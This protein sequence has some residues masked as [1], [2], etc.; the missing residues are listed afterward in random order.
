MRYPAAAL[1][2]SLLISVIGC[3]QDAEVP[4][5]P[6]PT[7]P[8]LAAAS[9]LAFR[10]VSAGGWHTCALTTT[11]LAYCW[12]VREHRTPAPVSGGLKFLMLSAGGSYIGDLNGQGPVS[13]GVTTALRLY[14]W[15]D[16]LVPHEVPGGRRFRAVSVGY[17]HTCAVNPYDVAFCWGSDQ[18]GQ[19]GTGPGDGSTNTPTRV[20]GGHKWRLVFAGASHTC[21]ATQDNKGYCWG[22]NNFNQ[23]GIGVPGGRHPEPTPIAG[24][25]NWRQ[26]RAGSGVNTGLNSVEIDEAV[27]CGVT[28]SDQAYCWGAG[29]TGSAPGA[30]STPKLVAGGR[31]YSTVQPG[32]WHSCGLTLAGAVFCWGQNDFGMLGRTGGSSQTPVR[33]SGNLEFETLSVD[34]SGFHACGLTAA[35]QVYCWGINSQG[36]LGDGT[37]TNRSTP[38]AVLQ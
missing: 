15:D 23:L 20:L 18:F 22:W 27:G 14:C 16:G 34:P 35:H 36:Q 38:V 8:S 4:T 17:E 1:A 6:A 10:T 28:Q 26:V 33:V 13:C 24:G 9:A 25:L 31:R 37:L 32:L 12:G 3:G 7:S 19:L 21:G 2:S 11:D 5:A 30:S 29:A